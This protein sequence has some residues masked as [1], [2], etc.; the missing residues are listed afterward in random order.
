MEQHDQLHLSTSLGTWMDGAR[1]RMH[2]ATCWQEGSQTCS[3]GSAMQA[4]W[5]PQRRTLAALHHLES[6]IYLRASIAL[7]HPFVTT[8]LIPQPQYKL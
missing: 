8:Q 7:Q 5:R 6:C 4:F 1:L 2:S 3:L